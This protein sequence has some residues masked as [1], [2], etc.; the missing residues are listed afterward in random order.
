VLLNSQSNS[1]SSPPIAWYSLRFVVF[2]DA[3]NDDPFEHRFRKV[4]DVTRTDHPFIIS[5][6]YVSICIFMIRNNN[7]EFFWF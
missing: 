3:L 1:A 2:D 4:L 7:Y 6:L 5:A